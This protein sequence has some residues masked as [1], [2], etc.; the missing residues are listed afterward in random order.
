MRT[1]FC[2]GEQK[3]RKGKKLLIRYKS[4]G[5]DGVLQEISLQIENVKAVRKMKGVNGQQLYEFITDTTHYYYQY[6]EK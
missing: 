1:I 2:I 6:L 5:K 3:P 4:R